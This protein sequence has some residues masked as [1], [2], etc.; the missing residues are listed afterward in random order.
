MP[1]ENTTHHMWCSGNAKSWPKAVIE[2]LVGR[3]DQPRGAQVHA[4]LLSDE[5]VQRDP[6]LPS[7]HLRAGSAGEN[8]LLE[9]P[10]YPKPSIGKQIFFFIFCGCCLWACSYLL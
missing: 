3:Q 1:A 4:M 8:P 7:P 2:H 10:A 5:G 9:I 6:P